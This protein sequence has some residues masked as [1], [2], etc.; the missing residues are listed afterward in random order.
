M[1]SVKGGPHFL[2]AGVL[3]QLGLGSPKSIRQGSELQS[4]G[5]GSLW[6]SCRVVHIPYNSAQSV[7][8]TEPVTLRSDMSYRRCTGSLERREHSLQA[9][10]QRSLLQGPQTCE[11]GEDLGLWVR[12][13]PC[14]W[15]AQNAQHVVR[16]RPGD[17]PTTWVQFQMGPEGLS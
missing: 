12:H 3:G 5:A 14:T 9:L 11:D 4:W 10:V 13:W 6:M 15:K 1:Q 16:A 17:S 2:P 7:F 8:S